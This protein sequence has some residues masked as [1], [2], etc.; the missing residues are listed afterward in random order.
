MINKIALENEGIYDDLT[1]L[2]IEF[3]NSKIDELNQFSSIENSKSDDVL[4]NIFVVI[5]T[6]LS[7]K[8]IYFEIE[9]LTSLI[10]VSIETNKELITDPQKLIK[11]I[12]AI[13]QTDSKE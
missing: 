2:Q 11:H 9:A 7:F 10:S 5:M 3:L 8:N 6:T 4:E 12:I 13:M 1:E